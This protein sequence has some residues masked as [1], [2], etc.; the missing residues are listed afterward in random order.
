MELRQAQ[1]VAEIVGKGS[2]VVGGWDGPS[3]L[4]GAFW[5]P[6]GEYFDYSQDASFHGRRASDDLRA[7]ISKTQ[8]RGGN[9]YFIGLLDLTPHQW[10]DFLGRRCGIPYSD[11]DTYRT[12]SSVIAKLPRGTAEISLRHLNPLRLRESLLQKNLVNLATLLLLSPT[13]R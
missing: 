8:A 9:V 6:N 1:H 7:A 4:Y 2:F 5:A 3:L 11:L 12:H 10:D 13:G